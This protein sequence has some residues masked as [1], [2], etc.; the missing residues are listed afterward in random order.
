MKKRIIELLTELREAHKEFRNQFEEKD[1]EALIL[2]Y[3]TLFREAVSCY[4]GEQAGKNRPLSKANM[5]EGTG[6]ESNKSDFPEASASKPKPISEKQANY[7]SIHKKE[8]IK[9]GFDLDNIQYSKDAFKII[10]QHKKLK[11][12]N[13]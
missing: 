8:L 13:E 11:E 3:P 6:K 5:Q 10:E 9:L 1:R 4:R 12:K 2:D 7:L